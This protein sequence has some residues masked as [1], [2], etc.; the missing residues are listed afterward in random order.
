MRATLE[1]AAGTTAKLG[2]V[3]GDKVKKRIFGANP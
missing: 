2:I 3:V 1:L